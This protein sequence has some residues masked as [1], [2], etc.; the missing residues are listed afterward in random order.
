MKEEIEKISRQLE[1]PDLF[2][3]FEVDDPAEF[4]AKN[5]LE[6]QQLLLKCV[7]EEE[8]LAVELEN[9]QLV[10]DTHFPVNLPNF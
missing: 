8:N 1:S 2:L 10:L 7:G 6:L 4:L 3:E 5:N 9:A